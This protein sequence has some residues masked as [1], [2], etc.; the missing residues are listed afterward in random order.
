MGLCASCHFTTKQ[1]RFVSNWSSTVKVINSGDGRL[2]EF[3][4]PIRACH[5]L[6]SHPAAFLCSSD[7]MFVGR[8]APQMSGNE[9]LQMGEIYFIMPLSNSNNPLSL[10]ELCSLAIKAGSALQTGS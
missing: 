7:A 4:R 5:V 10:Q 2:Q 6:S 3:R 9:E 8:I 1:G